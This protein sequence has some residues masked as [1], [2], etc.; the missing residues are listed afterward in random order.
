MLQ[1]LTDENVTLAYARQIRRLE[2]EIDIRAVGELGVP[3]KGTLDP[4]ILDWCELNRFVLITNNRK[5][6][7]PHLTEHLIKGQ[8]IPGILILSASMS[9]G[10]I[11]DE[12]IFLAKAAADDE[13]Q[14]QIRH[15][16]IV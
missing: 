10:A 12:L 9:F 4:E 15:M 13:F 2:P 5:S 11:I 7:P 14:D 6:M 16:P 8:H 3:P 1:Y